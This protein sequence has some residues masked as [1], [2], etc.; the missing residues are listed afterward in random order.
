MDEPKAP[1]G[2]D[3]MD[4]LASWRTFEEIQVLT[5]AL[6][7][8][9]DDAVLR[10]ALDDLLPV[11][12]IEALAANAAAVDLLVGRRWYVM[13]A[14]REDGAT[15][16]QIGN[17]LGITKQGAQDYYRRQI[18]L[19]ERRVGDLHDAPRARAALEHAADEDI[20]P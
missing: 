16:E 8:G 4:H 3:L 19:Q 7:R 13:Q 20:A 1:L 12:A 5:R 17:A 6:E 9:G 14:A 15:W 11:S 18:E 10:P 2:P